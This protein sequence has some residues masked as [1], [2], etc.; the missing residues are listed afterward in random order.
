MRHALTL[1]LATLTL[2]LVTQA[3]ADHR[4]QAI[5]AAWNRGDTIGVQAGW[6]REIDANA[7]GAQAQLAATA[8]HG[9]LLTVLVS[10]RVAP[11]IYAADVTLD[12]S[13]EIW[14]WIECEKSH[15]WCYWGR[16]RSARGGS[17]ESGQGLDVATTAMGVGLLGASEINPLG[18]AVLPMKLM[19]T[20]RTHTQA[21]SECI[22]W[23]SS[24]D[25]VG[26]GAGVANM[27][28]LAAA[29]TNPAVSIGVMFATAYARYDYAKEDAI[30]ECAEFALEMQQA[31]RGREHPRRQ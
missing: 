16:R 3:S 2:I 6:T 20:L 24:L 22:A 23:R 13:R 18:L 26:A 4:I 15:E 5:E 11:K 31:E 30:Y 25:S 14:L 19:L 12:K 21:Y 29:I 28:T 10:D 7:I 1:A 27:V 17:A 8:E 9:G